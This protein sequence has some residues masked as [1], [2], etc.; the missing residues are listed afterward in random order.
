MLLP[1]MEHLRRVTMNSKS[2]V[3]LL[4]FLLVALGVRHAHVLEVTVFTFNSSGDTGPFATSSMTFGVCNMTLYSGKWFFN[5][6]VVFM[7]YSADSPCIWLVVPASVPV[8]VIPPFTWI[9][10]PL[11]C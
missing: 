8:I 10:H 11:G 7:F 1:K 2:L 6:P 9:R 4:L 3:V 5:G